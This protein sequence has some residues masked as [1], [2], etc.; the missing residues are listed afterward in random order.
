VTL[1]WLFIGT[2]QAVALGLLLGSMTIAPGGCTPAARAG[3][4]VLSTIDAIGMGIS[5][6]A[7]W[8][9]DRGIEPETVTSALKAAQEKD[10]RTA[11][12]LLGDAVARSRAAG[13]PIP[14]DVEM[15]LRLAEGAVAA[16]AIEQGMRA[17]S[18]KAPDGGA[19][20]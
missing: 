11:L 19:K 10:Y 1:R 7:G 2:V 20:P 9:N 3:I 5:Q 13:D 8:C 4:P 6:I 16:T 15:T 18:G 14:A 17:L 12:A